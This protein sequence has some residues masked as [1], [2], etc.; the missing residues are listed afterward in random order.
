[1]F[2]RNFKA[3]LAVMVVFTLG[4]YYDAFLLLRAKD[5]GIAA[6]GLPLLWILL[7]V[8][9]MASSTPGGMLSDR[10]GRKKVIVAGWIVYFL[11]YTGFA[12]AKTP[13]HIW[14]LFGGYGFFF[15]LTESAEK[16]FVADLVPAD[17]RGSAFGLYNF[18]IGISALPASLL[19]G[20]LWQRYGV[21]PAFM[22]GAM[23]AL[24]AAVLLM[25]AVNDRAVAAPLP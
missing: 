20:V 13:A 18:A 22:F 25:L 21:V 11:A 17:A 10:F 8:V 12:L 19:M 16:A 2:D 9:K 7:H 6:A 24:A 5:A 3:F 4:N 1:M 15:G 14:L 23:L